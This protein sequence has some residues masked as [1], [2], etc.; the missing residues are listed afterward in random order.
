LLSKIVPVSLSLVVTIAAYFFVFIIIGIWH[1][2]ALNYFYWGLWHGAGLSLYRIWISIKIYL[3]APAS[4]DK[5]IKI[6]G[7]ILAGSI[8]FI[9]VSLG[10][11]FFQNRTVDLISVFGEFL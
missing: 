4:K 3:P 11:I 9:Y 1:G 10:W 6:A 2:D 8:T 7:R 5:S